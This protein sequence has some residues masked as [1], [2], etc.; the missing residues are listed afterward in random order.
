M[1]EVMSIFLAVWGIGM[2]KILTF[3]LVGGL[4]LAIYNLF[5]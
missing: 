2:I 3:A 4:L 1:S 5:R